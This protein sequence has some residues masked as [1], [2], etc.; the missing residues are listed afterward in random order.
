[1]CN[2][3]VGFLFYLND[4]LRIEITVEPNTTR[5]KN[6]EIKSKMHERKN[7]TGGENVVFCS[8]YAHNL[9]HACGRFGMLAQYTV[10][11]CVLYVYVCLCLC[12]GT[13][14]IRPI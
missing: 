5:K 8:K 4:F 12:I 13:T 1:M 7:R 10:Y 6:A 3:V 9:F 14:S 2:V 11:I